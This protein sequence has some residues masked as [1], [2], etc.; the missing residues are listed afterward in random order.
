MVPNMQEWNIGRQGFDEEKECGLKCFSCNSSS[1][2]FLPN[3]AKES[4]YRPFLLKHRACLTSVVSF[5]S[6]KELGLLKRLSPEFTIPHRFAL[7]F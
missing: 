4:N 3:H 2:F 1:F 5:Q 6:D 7:L